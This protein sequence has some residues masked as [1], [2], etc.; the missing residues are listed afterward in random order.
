MF[1]KIIGG[2][3]TI[4][5]TDFTQ[6]SEA[7]DYLGAFFDVYSGRDLNI[8]ANLA[9]FIRWW[10]DTHK[11]L[12]FKDALEHKDSILKFKWKE[13]LE[14]YMEDIEKYLLLV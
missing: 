8:P 11:T 12:N 14:P 5:D 10:E 9:F 13:K 3:H 1:V 4:I 6:K 7:E 2:K